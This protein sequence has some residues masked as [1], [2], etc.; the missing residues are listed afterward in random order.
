MPRRRITNPLPGNSQIR[1][2][3]KGQFESLAELHG[4]EFAVGWS[5]EEFKSLDA[6]DRVITLVS[7]DEAAERIL[8]F[9]MARAVVDEGEILTI[10]IAPHSRR[11]GLGRQLLEEIRRH[12]ETKGV[13]T[14]FL[15]VAIRNQAGI[16][17]Y[18]Q[19]GFCEAG[20]RKN[21][22][23]LKNGGTEDALLMRLDLAQ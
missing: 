9:A 7:T 19:Q 11:Q 17:L 1:V 14:I 23:R 6:N 21:Y 13:L 15:E 3:E 4:S 18:R 5:A 16:A 22:V 20:I 2:V 10:M 8:G 12:L